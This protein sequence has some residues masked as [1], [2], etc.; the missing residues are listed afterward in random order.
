V[1][2]QRVLLAAQNWPV[3]ERGLHDP[4]GESDLVPRLAPDG[5]PKQ[6]YVAVRSQHAIQVSVR[7]LLELVAMELEIPS[8][9]HGELATVVSTEKN[10]I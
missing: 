8:F 1:P 7:L 2:A 5:K 3:L 6:R 10:V 4:E 9:G